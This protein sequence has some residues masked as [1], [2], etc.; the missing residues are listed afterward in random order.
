MSTPRSKIKET[1]KRNGRR[2]KS[3]GNSTGERIRRRGEFDAKTRR[4]EETGGELRALSSPQNP[5][6]NGSVYSR[7][8]RTAR[9]K[10]LVLTI[11]TVQLH[12]R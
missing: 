11:S 5:T 4:D 9:H 3:M 8:R 7:E 12:Q 2:I 6:S 1:D 10:N